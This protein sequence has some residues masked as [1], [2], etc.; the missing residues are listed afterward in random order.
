MKEKELNFDRKRHVIYSSNAKKTIRAQLMKDYDHQE[1]EALWEKTQ[2]NY[3][4]FIET[5]PYTGAKKNPQATS[6][7]DTI[8]LFAYYE[9]VPNKP[10]SELFYKLNVEVFIPNMRT[11]GKVINLNWKWVERL[12]YAI[13]KIGEKAIGAR[14]YD[15]TWGNT[16]KLKV[17]PRKSTDGVKYEFTGCPI[18]DF[19][20]AN[21]FM[22]LM[23]QVCNSDYPLIQA[24]HGDLIR[25]HTVAMGYDTC[26]YWFVG[27]KSP[28]LKKY[29]RKEDE[30][31]FWYNPMEVKN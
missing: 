6:I 13:F 14:A 4:K 23:P 29:P 30:K 1:A 26:D 16:W 18:V 21:G 31:G 7:Y 20:K 27:N 28:Y 15:G 3:V 5:M 24:V 22:H 17:S 2:K 9:T 8:A 11:K 25:S 10:T 19:A 12:A